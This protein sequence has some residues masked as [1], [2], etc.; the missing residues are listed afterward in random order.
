[1]RADLELSLPDTCVVSHP[2]HVS[3]GFGGQ[4]TTWTDSASIPCRISPNGQAANE[5]TIGDRL[6]SAA[7]WIITLPA[8]TTVLHEDRIKSGGRTFEVVQ[9]NTDR[10]FEIDIRV[11]C[12][13]VI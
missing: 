1:M 13:E 2:T 10:S 5:D 8:F 6:R 4:T 11:A 9:V 12:V 3:D 7:P